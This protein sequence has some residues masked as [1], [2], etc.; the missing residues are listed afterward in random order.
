M[1]PLTNLRKFSHSKVSRY[2]VL[3][4]P[5]IQGSTRDYGIWSNQNIFQVFKEEFDRFPTKSP[6]GFRSRHFPYREI[7]LFCN[8]LMPDTWCEDGYKRSITAMGQTSTVLAWIIGGR[9]STIN[10]S[11]ARIAGAVKLT[12]IVIYDGTAESG[13]FITMTRKFS[14]RSGWMLGA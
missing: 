7:E 11:I 10:R 13:R 6:S 9:S 1:V 12:K 14:V 2:T 8:C 4:L 5:W 3:H